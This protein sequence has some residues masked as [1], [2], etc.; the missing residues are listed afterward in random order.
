MF[1]DTFK[2][3]LKV[4]KIGTKKSSNKTIQVSRDLKSTQLSESK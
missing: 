3:Y 4:K 2:K 1:V